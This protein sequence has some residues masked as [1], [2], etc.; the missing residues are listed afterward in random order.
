M[1]DI[2]LRLRADAMQF[3]GEDDCVGPDVKLLVEEASDEIERLREVLNS[4]AANTYGY[5]PNAMSD[6]E[7]K[8]YFSGLIFN[9][10]Y[11]ARA[12]LKMQQ[13]AAANEP[14]QKDNEQ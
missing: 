11:K 4:I 13:K 14:A 8:D 2:V 3:R 5:E 1:A 7:A 6:E 12:A 10:Q 9:A